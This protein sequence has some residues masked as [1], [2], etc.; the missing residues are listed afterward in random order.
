MGIAAFFTCAAPEGDGIEEPGWKGMAETTA[1]P[2]SHASWMTLIQC[3]QEGDKV[4]SDVSQ[5][6]PLPFDDQRGAWD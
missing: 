3:E 1:R 5:G 4:S 6:S 2:P